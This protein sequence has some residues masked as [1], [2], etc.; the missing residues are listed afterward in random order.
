GQV[1]ITT[2]N[3]SVVSASTFS[4][5][6]IA[7]VWQLGLGIPPNAQVR[8]SVIKPDCTPVTTPPLTI[9]QSEGTSNG[10]TSPDVATNGAS[11]LVSWIV[12]GNVYIRIG[13]SSGTFAM[14]ETNL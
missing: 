8:T 3:G 4:N 7:V 9:S 2:D 13:N 6:N 14:G 11:S 12:D 5:G 10:P 1:S